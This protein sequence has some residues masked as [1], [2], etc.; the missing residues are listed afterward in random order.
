MLA[1]YD[2]R[3]PVR[4]VRLLLIL[5]LRVLD[6]D[7]EMQVL[8]IVA[9]SPIL[10]VACFNSKDKRPRVTLRQFAGGV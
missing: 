6:T 9:I 1:G 2:F 3:L 10:L 8:E 7:S 4:R 5:T